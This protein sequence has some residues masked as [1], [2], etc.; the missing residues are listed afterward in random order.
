MYYGIKLNIG[1][2][3]GDLYVSYAVV[4]TGEMLGYLILLSMDVVGHKRLHI[5][6]LAAT[7]VSCIASIFPIMFAGEC[8]YAKL[9]FVCLVFFYV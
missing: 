2:L 3:G 8:K 1:K 4:V 5:I 9:N 7:G 6:C